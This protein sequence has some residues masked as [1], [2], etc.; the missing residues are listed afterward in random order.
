MGL[1]ILLLH[2]GREPA[3]AV[4]RTAGAL[5]QEH[6]FPVRSADMDR[7]SS[8]ALPWE[9]RVLFLLAPPLATGLFSVTG[10]FWHRVVRMRSLDLR[11]LR[12][13]I[14]AVGTHGDTT[15]MP[16]VAELDRALLQQQARRSY[17]AMHC[18][19]DDEISIRVWLCGSL[20]MW[21]EP[22][23]TGPATPGIPLGAVQV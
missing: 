15:L 8:D 23:P 12:Y 2:G 6:G 7:L 21:R 22:R 19:P 5:A 16:V 11:S 17:P 9:S 4:A 3:A 1:P 10:A 20:A 18:A 13:S 14:L